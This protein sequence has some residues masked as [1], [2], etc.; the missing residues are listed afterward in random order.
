MIY[1]IIDLE[2]TGGKKNKITEIAIFNTN[3][4]EIIEEYHSLVNPGLKIPSHITRITGISNETVQDA[5]YFYEIAKNVLTITKDTIFVAHNVNFDYNVLKNEYREL[6]YQYNRKKLCTVKLSRA[7]FPGLKSYS[8]GKLCNALNIPIFQRHRAVG[9]AKA[10]YLLFKKIYQKKNTG[11][12]ENNIVHKQISISQHINESYLENFPQKTGVYYFWNSKNE[13]I[14]IGKSIN[15][16][17]RIKSHFSDPANK[18]IKLCENTAKITYELTGNDLIAQ[19]KE[20]AEIKKY[21]PLYNRRQKR[22]G[23]T[24]GINYFTNANGIIEFK[25]DYIKNMTNPMISF[26]S[27]KNAKDFMISMAK[28]NHLCLKFCGL[29]KGKEACF[30]YQIKQCKGVCCQKETKETY[31]KRALKLV[32]KF[33]AKFSNDSLFLDGRNNDEKGFILFKNG[34]YLGYGFVPNTSKVHNYK[35][36]HKNL[37]EQKDNNEIRRIISSYLNKNEH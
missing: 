15:I 29:E 24:Y 20:S 10:T 17:K 3:G 21:Y 30:Y 8:L 14:Y 2:T 5:P 27:K 6:G 22:L 37:I 19:L 1:S 4:H 33:Q 31:N 23:E 9:D 34:V 36:L 18:E 32:V 28:K 25:I 26:S 7:N 16:K 11:I 35:A 13:I 12:F